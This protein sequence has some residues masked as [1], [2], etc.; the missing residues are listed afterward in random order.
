MPVVRGPTEPL[1]FLSGARGDAP[2]VTVFL[3]GYAKRYRPITNE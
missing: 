2:D 3:S 1:D